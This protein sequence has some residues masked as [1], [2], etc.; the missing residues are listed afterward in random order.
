MAKKFEKVEQ[1]SFWVRVGAIISAPF[2]GVNLALIAM[3]LSMIIKLFHKTVLFN[4]TFGPYLNYFLVATSDLVKSS[5]STDN[6][7]APRL[8]ARYESDK[9]INDAELDVYTTFAL[10]KELFIM[11]G[12]FLLR[13]LRYLIRSFIFA[14]WE[15][16]HGI[17]IYKIKKVPKNTQFVV[18]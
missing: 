6:T 16:S 15:E 18:V 1:A 5:Q 7:N 2:L 12:F 17:N 11:F 4:T 9:L 13:F 8:I 3:K 14:K 10:T